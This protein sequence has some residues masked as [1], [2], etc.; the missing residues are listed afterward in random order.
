[1][2]GFAAEPKSSGREYYELRVYRLK[3]GADNSLLHGFLEKALVPGLNKQGCKPI[4]VFTDIEPKED[5]A[6]VHVLIPHSSLDSFANV[7]TQ[8]PGDADFQKNG[9]EYLQTS[10][11]KPGFVRIDTWLLLAFS[12]IPKIEL[13]EY[14]KNKKPRI[15]EIRTYES[16]S[17]AKAQKKIDMFNNGEIEIMRETNLGPIFFGQSLAGANLPHLTYMLS[18]ENREE[19]KKHFG[20]FGKHPKWKTLSADKQYSDTVS[21]IYNRFVE[22]TAYSQ[23]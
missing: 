4:G 7:A 19:H 20:D 5:A 1:L 17:E 8:L 21:K 12:G 10:K 23:I 16:Y 11:A 6:A 2:S 9:E 3:T 18:A 14:S 22:P 15:F 13:P